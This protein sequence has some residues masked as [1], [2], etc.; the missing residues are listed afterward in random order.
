MVTTEPDDSRIPGR[1]PS[2]T[3][4]SIVTVA[5]DLFERQG[6]E[7]TSVDQIAEAA[8]ISR[9][10]LFRYFPGKA[11]IAW[12]EFDVQIDG[13]R[14]ELNEIPATTPLR[15]ALADSLVAFNTFPDSETQ[16]HR[17][18]MGL[19]LGVD[20]LQ[21]HSTLMYADWRRAV[22]EFVA[23]RRGE[24]VHDLIPAATA[25]AALGIAI[26]AYRRW[27]SEPHADQARLHELLRQGTCILA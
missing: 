24:A 27:V 17:L 1:R 23:A 25:Y 12:G 6:Y 18:R 9:R 13:M 8:H 7:S 19:L 14:R 21:A 16:V 15:D 11:A 5:L 22:A 4:A 3:R 2:T 20:E 10:T 26:S